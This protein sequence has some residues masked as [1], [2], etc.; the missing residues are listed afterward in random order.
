MA[1]RYAGLPLPDRSQLCATLSAESDSTQIC[2]TKPIRSP[3][4]PT[5]VEEE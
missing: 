5:F 2:K 3:F 4:I 1:E